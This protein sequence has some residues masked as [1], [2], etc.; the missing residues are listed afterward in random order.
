MLWVGHS[1]TV[2]LRIKYFA[3][4]PNSAQTQIFSDKIFVVKVPAM[5]CIRYEL[6]I[7]Q[8]IIFTVILRP[9]K[10]STEKILG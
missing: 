4:L 1:H 5:H 3:V 9:S 8:K 2:L 6:K 10:I 7:S